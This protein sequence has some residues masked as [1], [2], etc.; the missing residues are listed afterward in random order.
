M[1]CHCIDAESSM[2]ASRCIV[3]TINTPLI[4]SDL[5]P[6]IK[7]FGFNVFH[8]VS[9]IWVS[10]RQGLLLMMGTRQRYI[11]LILHACTCGW[12]L[13]SEQVFPFSWGVFY[14]QSPWAVSV[15]YRALGWPHWL[16]GGF[17][18]ILS[19]KDAERHSERQRQ[20]WG[21]TVLGKTTCE[22]Q[23]SKERLIEE[24]ISE[25]RQKHLTSR[26]PHR[27]WECYIPKNADYLP[28]FV[29]SSACLYPV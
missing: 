20:T 12:D 8:C 17:V 29:F 6:C 23:R 16:T 5:A 21:E 27:I 3:E 1:F 7:G 11:V 28:I 25:D 10:T 18:L 24:S 22:R 15:L 26:L 4:M 13:L 9:W 14:I 19:D 2:S